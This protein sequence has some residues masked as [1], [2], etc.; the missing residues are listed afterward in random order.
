MMPDRPPPTALESPRRWPRL[1]KVAGELLGHPRVRSVARTVAQH[2]LLPWAAAIA[3]LV[4]ALTAVAE[5]VDAV[6]ER[7]DL[8]AYDPAITRDTVAARRAVLTPIAWGFTTLASTPC[9]SALVLLVLVW[10][11]IRRNWRLAGL[12][13]AT[14]GVSLG[15][16]VGLKWIIGRDRPG[17][18]DV[19]G[20]AETSFAFPSGHTLNATVFFGLVAGIVMVRLRSARSRAWV[21]GA[22]LMICAMVGAS[23]IYL[24][25]HWF[26][27]VLGGFGIGV[28]VLSLSAL[29]ALLL[30]GA[31]RIEPER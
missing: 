8:A 10:T 17:I 2:R 12:V 5:L 24:G 13:S 1:H 3:V 25:F 15:L 23:R 11:A 28:I 29:V 19:I 26:T 18:D 20:T 22:W 9:M 16:T 27:D 21:G 30:S 7:D 31:T 14:M 4:T 6:I